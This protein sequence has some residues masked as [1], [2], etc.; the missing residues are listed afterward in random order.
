MVCSTGAFWPSRR[1][2]TLA[3]G[4]TPRPQRRDSRNEIGHEIGHRRERT[5]AKKIDWYYHRKG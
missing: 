3:T 1:V 4:Q 5:M 2:G